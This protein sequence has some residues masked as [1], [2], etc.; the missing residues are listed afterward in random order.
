[1]RDGD[2]IRNRNREGEVRV[3]V[4]AAPET[5]IKREGVRNSFL[6]QGRKGGKEMRAA[7]VPSVSIT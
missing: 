5:E 1:M 7:P 3:N 6:E 4:I 2:E